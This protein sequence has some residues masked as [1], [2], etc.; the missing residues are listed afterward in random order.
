MIVSRSFA[1][2]VVACV[3]VV[4]GALM[5]R[6]A[7]WDPPR[8][9][10]ARGPEG[11]LWARSCWDETCRDAA[12]EHVTSHTT[13]VRPRGDSMED[14]PIKRVEMPGSLVWA[15]PSD[16]LWKTLDRI[17]AKLDLLLGHTPIP[18][19]VV[20]TPTADTDRCAWDK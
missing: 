18:G 6:V 7:T 13:W 4:A 15:A 16:P 9:A 1:V 10:H 17:E 11:Y 8:P 14:L 19:V 2:L 20:G 12:T 3:G 5:V